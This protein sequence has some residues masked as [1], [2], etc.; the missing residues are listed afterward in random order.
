MIMTERRLQTALLLVPGI[1]VAS[2][3]GCAATTR[4]AGEPAPPSPG[5]IPLAETLS[6]LIE[7]FNAHRDR[8]R[9][10]ALVS[11]TCGAC[12]A[13]AVA[14]RETL[15]GDSGDADLDL[16]IVW[17]DILPG[18][19]AA[20]AARA[21]AIFDDPR[22]AQFHDPGR[23]TG[24]AFARGLLDRPPAWDI[25]LFYAAGDSWT[26]G[27]PRP[28]HWMHQ[29][30]S[31]VADKNRYRTGPALAAGFH[32][33]LLDLGLNPKARTP[34]TAQHLADG[35]RRANRIIA[36]AARTPTPGADTDRWQ[37]VRCA[38]RGSIGQCSLAGWRHLVAIRPAP[39][40]DDQGQQVWVSGGG[41]PLDSPDRS[42]AGGEV[43]RL[44]IGAM[45]CPDCLL[46]VAAGLLALE[47]VH[48]V[49][50]D[51]DPGRARVFV[52]PPG[53]VS[54]ERLIGAVVEQGYEAKVAAP[55]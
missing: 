37:C 7:R 43:V 54:R 28:A 18:D 46:Q 5:P 17:I 55:E 52:R 12:V 44:E 16:M 25:Y 11:P 3:I 2:A 39:A 29:L 38:R 1:A 40:G 6:P 27:P 33:A 26:D 47:Q 51:F 48:R 24:Q 30:G 4:L 41:S 8:P 53:A 20:A 50:V 13:G 23:L 9:F 45:S 22:V 32:E 14:V 35:K 19:D 21:A 36:G 42:E 34:P 31:K 10:V 49:E 15:L